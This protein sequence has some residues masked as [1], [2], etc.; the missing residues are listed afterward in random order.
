[1]A[2]P[3]EKLRQTT[4]L[5]NPELNPLHNPTL[6]RNLGR[7]AQVYFT[8]PPEKREEAVVKLLRELQHNEGT[9]N[10]EDLPVHKISEVSPM[11]EHRICPACNA[12]NKLSQRFC[13]ICGAKLLEL[14]TLKTEE[15]LSFPRHEPESALY[16][17]AQSA[18]AD[19]EWIR[20]RTL[21]RFDVAEPESRVGWGK[22]AV[23]GILFL[24]AAFGGLEW[25][26]RKPV[27]V[28]QVIAGPQNAPQ[29]D[30]ASS[31]P[32]SSTVAPA[33]QTPAAQPPVAAEA[34]SSAPEPAGREA[35]RP[36]PT[37]T[38][39]TSIPTREPN[40]AADREPLR[41]AG[42]ETQEPQTAEAMNGNQ[43]LVLAQHFL[44]SVGHARD[45]SEAAKW[46]WKAVGKQN[47][48]ATLLL[49]DLYS[50]GDGVAKNC[51]QARLLLVAAAK[52]GNSA[53]ADKL[54]LIE[55]GGCR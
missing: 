4:D 16:A 31:Q 46:L 55:S 21:T 30:P 7:W 25:L 47:T 17:A 9:A 37:K 1:M 36:A 38:E 22:Y 24:L 14:P 44:G 54:R 49:A 3:W 5:P 51:D 33:S 42:N 12:A 18:P 50:R 28:Q 19:T 20:E 2:E 29:S 6:G 41:G 40:Q 26:S 39:R 32:S 23:L 34:M 35:E 43:E 8:T 52:K 45:T 10:G 53:A 15:V 48:T 11:Q 27:E 13:G